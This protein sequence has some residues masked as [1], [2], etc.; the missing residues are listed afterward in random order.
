MLKLL[1]IEDEPSAVEPVVNL[2][3]REQTDIQC[4]VTLFADAESR[5][6][7]LRPDI[8][9]LDLLV[10]GATPEPESA[11]LGT[12]DF[13]WNQHFCPLV[14]YSARPDIHD[15]K[16]EP[17]PFV[18]SIQK[19]KDSPRKVMDALGELRPQ[20]EALTEAEEHVRQSFSCAMRDV[21]PYAFEAFTD[22]A[23]R[24]ETIKRS[25]RRRLAALM[26]GLSRDATMLASWEQYL[27]PP[28]SSDIKLGDVLRK[29]DGKWDDP[30]SFRVALT[31][32][33]DLVASNGRVPKVDR[34]LAAKCCSMR[35]GL[36]LTSLKGMGLTKLKD[37]LP[38][39]MLS[40]GYFEA[41]IPFP[42]LKGRIPTMAADLRDLEFISVGDIGVE[43]RPFL[44]VASIDSPFREMVAWAYLHTA[45]RPGLP[46]RDFNSWR[47]EIMS[48]LGNNVATN[49]HESC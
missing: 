39:T 8:V 17:H 40:H 36:D 23:Q 47:D 14:I 38:G 48:T 12:R 2:L 25:G 35:V 43:N 1:F 45:C 20:V 9:I 37:R 5:V 29:A 24:T 46:D 41:T 32:S 44:R 3:K 10:G 16:Y 22:A 4:E 18:K 26:D 33:C 13:I 19:G 21:A 30:S 49:R 42:C 34:V 6:V 11:G 31:P 15:E 7:T 28:V 27:C